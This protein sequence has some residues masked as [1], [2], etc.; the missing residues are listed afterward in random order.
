MLAVKIV[1]HVLSFNPAGSKSCQP[2]QLR[3]G[4]APPAATR[5]ICSAWGPAK[6]TK[7]VGC[8]VGN[9]QK[10]TKIWGKDGKSM[11]K[12]ICWFRAMSFL[13]F[14][15]G[16]SAK[17][18]RVYEWGL[19]TYPSK[20]WSLLFI[21]A[22][23]CLYTARLMKELLYW[24]CQIWC[25]TWPACGCARLLKFISQAHVL[26]QRN[27]S[28]AI[29]NHPQFIT[30]CHSLYQHFWEIGDGGSSIFYVHMIY[31]WSEALI[32]QPASA[33]S[34]RTHPTP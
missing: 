24:L 19:L 10:R 1:R 18:C 16:V 11:E 6:M 30:V 32:K 2:V 22:C 7:D 25:W 5:C 17:N 20:H 23:W 34:L 3:R 13:R 8:R 28:K 21:D 9:P 14:C 26:K 27:F 12:H 15:C 31:K 33:L 4:S 29:Q